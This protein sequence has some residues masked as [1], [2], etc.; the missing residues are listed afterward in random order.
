MK[1]KKLLKD[2]IISTLAI[3]FI[4]GVSFAV[5]GAWY[6]DSDSKT[7]TVTVGKEV[8]VNLDT[9]SVNANAV[10]PGQKF[11]IANVKLQTP[12]ECSN[13]YI[14][15]LIES[16]SDFYLLDDINVLGDGNTYSWV[17]HEQYF[18]LTPI[19]VNSLSA[20]PE[21]TSLHEVVA[22]KT[23]SIEIQN[24]AVNTELTNSSANLASD[25]VVTA[26]AVQSKNYKTSAWEDCFVTFI[27]Q[28]DEFYPE[29][30]TEK[31][32][33]LKADIK[34]QYAGDA[35]LAGA[36]DLDTGVVY[37]HNWDF[38]SMYF[39]AML[40]T[41]LGSSLSQQQMIQVF[42]ETADTDFIAK[43]C[44]L[45][46]DEFRQQ[47]QAELASN[48]PEEITAM[49]D[50]M[51]R[52]TM[53]LMVSL[54]FNEYVMI[55][56]PGNYEPLFAFKSG[57]DSVSQNNINYTVYPELGMALFYKYTGTNTAV[58]IPGEITYNGANLQV[59]GYGNYLNVL[60]N[61][62]NRF[63]EAV[64]SLKSAVNS[65]PVD[66]FLG[67]NNPTELI[68]TGNA[69]EVGKTKMLG[70]ASP[71]EM[72]NKTSLLK[73]ALPNG[74]LKMPQGLL[75]GL[76]GLTE[77]TIPYV[78]ET[79]DN[80]TANTLFYWL[81]GLSGS[82]SALGPEIDQLQ[83]EMVQS[84]SKIIVTQ[85]KTFDAGA[86]ASLFNVTEIQI[87]QMEEISV[88][89]FYSSPNLKNFYIP[90]SL[91]TIN[92]NAFD[93]CTSLQNAFCEG[94]LQDI[95]AI[96]MDSSISLDGLSIYVAGEWEFDSNGNM[97]A[98]I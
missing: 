15:I 59:N 58:E 34:S 94:T 41:E 8:S 92:A 83:P 52:S 10:M 86:M 78:G 88:S 18:Y 33:A 45:L 56:P 25:I 36:R 87:L 21:S 91:K 73:L 97:V 40:I 70:L 98:T 69:I 37:W 5:S 82:L 90:K 75:T 48:T 50:D 17:K 93:G 42:Q 27:G 24:I 81:Y 64:T 71:F 85:Q 22:S 77:L 7:L 13:C 30:F 38:D 54:S 26:Q 39:G 43:D 46:T 20:T 44:S 4:V 57:M 72:I 19:T 9:S 47:M 2:L 80:S 79:I 6:A 1:N 66:A 14:R 49:I 62:E 51:G 55:L 68:L 95:L 16:N 74:I 3:I 12:A 65:F 53:A 89:M 32:V 76:T 67:I 84:L 28:F 11:N 29:F 63:P 31:Y 96:N 60:L 35:V 61:E 23:L